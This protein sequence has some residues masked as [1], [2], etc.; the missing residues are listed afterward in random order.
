[1]K[2][3]KPY[4]FLDFRKYPKF[5]NS[6]RKQLAEVNANISIVFLTSLI[7][8]LFSSVD[9]INPIMIVLG[10]VLAGGF[11]TLSLSLLKGVKS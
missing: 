6:Q 5:N 3:I 10:V 2:S 8:P 4:T 9:S 11:I 7:A 1:M